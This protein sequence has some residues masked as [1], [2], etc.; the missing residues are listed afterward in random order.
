M[1]DHKVCGE[2]LSSGT[3]QGSNRP[4]VSRNTWQP[5]KLQ[6]RRNRPL[7]TMYLD[8]AV[9]RTNSSPGLF[10]SVV[11]LTFC[12]ELCTEHLSI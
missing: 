10:S 3:P 4:P 5:V 7:C 9:V 12:L 6:C 2:S 11:V 8:L 1:S